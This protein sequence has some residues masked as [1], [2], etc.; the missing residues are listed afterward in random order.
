MLP[1]HI[2]GYPADIA[3]FER[4]GPPIVEDACEAL[5]A[6]YADGGAVGSRGHPAV[7]GFY[8]NKQLTTGEGGMVVIGDASLEGADR[9][10]AKPGP[11]AGY[12][13][14][15]PRPARVQLPA[16]GRGLRLGLAQL[17]HLDEMLAGRAR[18]AASTAP[19]WRR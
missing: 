3:G 4:L 6:I 8:P 11:R 17:S 1:V 7:F 18:V 14:A 12:G 13:L 16:V 10:R 15:R 19:L 2:F 9:L 5:G